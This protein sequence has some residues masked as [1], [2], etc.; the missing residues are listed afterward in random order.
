VTVAVQAATV[1]GSSPSHT[2]GILPLCDVRGRAHAVP[3][4]GRCCVGQVLGAAV[5]AAV[6]SS[7]AVMR[8]AAADVERSVAVGVV[9]QVCCVT[10]TEGRL[11]LDLCAAK[12]STGQ[13]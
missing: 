6:D 12:H 11:Q 3:A 2:C 13:V 7:S 8:A 4:A 5:L 9:C 1:A 10:T